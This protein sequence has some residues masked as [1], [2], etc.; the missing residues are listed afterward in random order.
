M[1]RHAFL[2]GGGACLWL[3]L[4]L[5]PACAQG[6]ENKPSDKKD[7]EIATLN[8]QVQEK[9]DIIKN[10]VEAVKQLTSRVE[11]LEKERGIA[12]PPVK[13]GEEPDIPPIEIP[14]EKTTLPGTPPGQGG[15]GTTAGGARGSFTPDIAVIGNNFGRFISTRGDADRNRLQLGEFELAL[16]QPIY[17]GIKFNAQLAGE[18]EE[19]FSLGVEEAY[20]S[21]ARVGHLPFGGYL[22]RKRL[23][24][25]KVNPIHQHARP[26]VDQPAVLTHLLGPDGLVGNGAAFTYLLPFKNIFANLE[27]GLW[28]PDQ[29]EDGITS[30][31]GVF[32][33]AGLGVSNNFPIA[34]LWLSKEIG[35]SRELELGVT[36]GF[37]KSLYGDRINL[38]GLDFTYRNFPGTFKRFMLQGEAFWHQRHDEI[39]GTGAHTRSG[40]YGLLTYQ[41]DQFT[42][43]GFRYDNSEFPW[44]LP[45]REQSYSLMWTNRLSEGTLLRLQ[46][47]TGSRTGDLF[48]PDSRGFNEVWLQ[49]IWAGGSHKHP[50]Q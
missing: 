7:A 21:F 12:P 2:R 17:T 22:G 40:H 36:H 42:E 37:G 41:P 8:K 35:K 14:G 31:S 48:L 3:A 46:Y 30:P 28:R 15:T 49:F 23:D 9:D 11:R 24:I 1:I 4:A 50:L 43:Y 29:A 6:T 33:P 13:P 26:Y 44:P 16:E 34:R 27:F 32:Y 18:F 5:S 19:N 25:G 47:K 39:G 10:L 20:A 45:G 38:T